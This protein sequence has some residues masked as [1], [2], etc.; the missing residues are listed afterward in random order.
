MDVDVRKKK[1]TKKQTRE[2][3]IVKPRRQYTAEMALVFFRGGGD[4][5]DPKINGEV[6]LIHTYTYS[7][8]HNDCKDSS[9]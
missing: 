9:L 3:I 6:S 7:G 8:I 1:R 5:T 2:K 4:G